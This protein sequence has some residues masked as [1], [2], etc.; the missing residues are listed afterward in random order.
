MVDFRV[1]ADLRLWRRFGAVDHRHVRYGGHPQCRDEP[2]VAS[3]LLPGAGLSAGSA[4]G[5]AGHGTKDRP[6]FVQLHRA[7]DKAAV[8]GIFDPAPRL[9][10]HKH[11]RAGHMGADAAVPCDRVQ[12]L[13]ALT[14]F[15]EKLWLTF[16]DT[17]TVHADGRMTFK[18]RGDTEI[19]A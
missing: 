5:N 12:E 7:W 17:V 10:R 19:E 14:E 11:Y 13:D 8:C 4:D 1:C 3:D 18:F 6:D 9:L 15:D 2:A 16:I